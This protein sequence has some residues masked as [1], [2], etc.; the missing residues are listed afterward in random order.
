MSIKALDQN[1]VKSLT[2]TQVITS[3]ATAVKELVENS[4]DAQA[5]SIEINLVSIRKKRHLP[6]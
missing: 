4:I 2:T 1:T 6:W 5:K 3:V